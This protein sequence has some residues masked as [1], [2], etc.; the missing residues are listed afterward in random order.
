M[1]YGLHLGPWRGSTNLIFTRQKYNLCPV[2]E[3][4]EFWAQISGSLMNK[5]LLLLLSFLRNLS[6]C[7]GPLSW[8]RAEHEG[9]D[10]IILL[11][12]PKG[13]PYG[14]QKSSP[15]TWKWGEIGFRRLASGFCLFIV[16]IS[17]VC[18]HTFHWSMSK[19]LRMKKT[20]SMSTSGHSSLPLALLDAE[21]TLINKTWSPRLG[22]FQAREKTRSS[23]DSRG[24]VS[25]YL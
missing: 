14:Q 24:L 10:Y 6:K 15:D 20:H 25:C 18:L 4:K 17:C 7:T 3:G 19:M 2:H 22:R 11:Y 23:E 8:S 16:N 9:H 21:G 1:S 5:S 13:S 12:W